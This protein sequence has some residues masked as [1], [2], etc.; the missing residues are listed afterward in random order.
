MNA[1]KG[2]LLQLVMNCETDFFSPPDATHHTSKRLMAR[3]N[4]NVTIPVVFMRHFFDA[5]FLR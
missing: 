1:S 4:P 2:L 3:R 5:I